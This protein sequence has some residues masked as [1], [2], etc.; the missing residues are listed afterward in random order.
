MEWVGGRVFAGKINLGNA[1]RT[2]DKKGERERER[3]REEEEEETS[4]YVKRTVRRRLERRE[5]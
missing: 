5:R 4:H 1:M 2:F 3:E